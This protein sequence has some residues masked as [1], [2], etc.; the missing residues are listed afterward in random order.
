MSTRPVDEFIITQDVQ[1]RP[2]LIPDKMMNF[3]IYTWVA[4]G[5]NGLILILTLFELVNY[6]STQ[7]FPF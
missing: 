3:E 7:S 2:W 6:Y 1:Y 5:I 4:V